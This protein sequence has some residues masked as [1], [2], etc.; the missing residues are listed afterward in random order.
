MNKA[1][2]LDRDGTINF[3]FGYVHKRKDL[4]FITHSLKAL[5]NLISQ[6]FLLIIITNQSGIGRKYYRL[7]DYKDFMKHMITK[8]SKEGISISAQYVCPHHPEVDCLCRKPKTSNFD[9]AIKKFNIDITRSYIIGDK[10]EDIKVGE[11]IGVHTILVKTGKAGNDHSF[12][13]KPNFIA[14]NLY[15]AS[16]WIKK[17]SK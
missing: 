15:E 3:D 13:V 4:K 6:G 8:L 9:K 12:K 17:N 2:F 1:I 14:K 10:T 7:S 5:K 16:Q 11:N